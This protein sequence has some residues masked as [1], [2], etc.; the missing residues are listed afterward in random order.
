MRETMQRLL[1]TFAALADLSQE[2]ANTSD[3]QEMVRTSLHLLLGTLAIRRGAVAEYDR[4]R[5]VLKFIATRGMGASMQDDLALDAADVEGLRQVRFCGVASSEEAAISF[6]ERYRGFLQTQ[7]IDMIVPLVV[8]NEPVGLVL[9][10]EK[11][12]GEPFTGDDRDVVCSMARHIGVGIH[13]HRLLAELEQQAEEN[14]RLYDGMRAIYKDTVRAF[15][16]AIDSKDKYTHGHSERVGKYSEIIAREM[17]WS[18][19]EVEGISVAGYLHDVGKLVVER[20]ILNAPYKIDA[21]KSSEL[22][23][24][25]AAGYEI[26]Q[27]IRHHYADISLMARHHH[28][29]IDGRGYPDGLKGDEIPM[30]AKIIT[31]ADS[32][33]AMTTDRPYKTRRSIEDVIEDL[34]RNTGKQ[35]APEVV[36]SFC[37]A[38]LKEINGETRTRPIIKMLGKGYIDPERVMPLLTGLIADLESG[39][40]VYVAGNA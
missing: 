35:F 28:E 8:R 24:H 38:L 18:E 30:G 6:V 17:G 1:H 25:P 27:P 37:R 26:L 32:F 20:D 31:L 23:R 7:R 21:K 29:R 5:Q 11:A 33:D 39:A 40:S 19:E 13:T 15:A 22:N 9:L 14:R 34:R 2:I 3:F 4:N 10:G 16:A 12:S 36:T